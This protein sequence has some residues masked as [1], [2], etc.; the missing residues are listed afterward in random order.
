MIGHITRATRHLLFWSLISTAFLLS[1]ARIF[2]AGLDEY[3]LELEDKIRQAI[4]VPFKIGHLEAGLRGFNPEIILRDIRIEAEDPQNKPDLQLREIRLGL[5]FWH[6]LLSWDL[7]SASRVTLVGANVHLTRKEDGSLAIKG[8]HASDEQ[9]LWL[10]RGKQYEILDSQITWQDLK[11][12]GQKVHL[13]RFDVVLKN[14]FSDRS[15]EIHL[16]SSLPKQYGDSFRISA[17]VKGDIF[18]ADDI[19]GQLYIEGTDLQA[20]TLIT[21][22]LPLGLDLRSGAGDIKVWSAWKHSRPYQIDGYIQAQ[23]IDI[24]KNQGKPIHMDTFQASFAWSEDDGRWRLAGYD[25][26][27][28]TQRQRWPDGAFY[29]QQDTE[30]NLSALI[31]QLDLPAAMLLAPLIVPTGHDHA[32][33]LKLNPTG[34]LRDVSLFVSHDLQSYAVSGRFDDLGTDHYAAIPKLRHLSGQ[35]SV[36]DQYGQV[37]FDSHDVAADVDGLFRNTVSIKLLQGT[38][39]WWQDAE[40][41]QVYS[42]NLAMDSLDFQTLSSL[43]L[44]IPKTSASPVLDMR[45]HFGGFEDISQ[46]KK[47][48]PAKLMDEDAVAWLDDAFIKGRIRQGEMCIQGALDQFPFVT[49]QGRF[50]TVFTIENGE[51][52]FNEDWP[53][54]H[55]LYA[56]VQFLGEDLQVAISEGRSEKV[57]IDQAVVTIPALADSEHVYVW[58]KVR[59]QIMDG[60]AFL[61]QSPLRPQIEPV[62]KVLDGDGETQIDLD[63]KIP[64]AETDPVKVKVDAELKGAQLTLKPI[65]LKV[66]GIKGILNFTEDRIAS[67]PLEARTLGYPIQGRLSSDEQATYLGI[68]GSTSFERLKKQ[69]TFLPNDVASGS[70]SYQARLALPYAAEQPGQ[71]NITTDL[72]G[73]AIKAENGLAKTSD[74]EMPLRLNFQLD[75]GNL[76]PLQLHYGK[77]LQAELLIDKKRESLFSGHLVLG[78]G[79]ASRYGKEGLKIDIRQA[80]F[81]LSQA[82]SSFGNPEQSRFPQIREIAIDTPQLIWQG[83]SLGAFTGR[84]Q[85]QD[86]AW[87]GEL[88]SAMAKGAFHIPN[89]LGGNNRILL[90]MDYLNLSELSNFHLD[91]AENAVTELPLIDI[92]SRQLLWRTVDLGEL[93]LQTERLG[94]GIHFKKIQLHNGSSKIDVTADWLKLDSGTATQVKG[95]LDMENFGKFLS[96]LGYTDDI[97]ETSANISFKG[98]WH[99]GPHQFA[100]DRLNGFLQLDLKDGRISSIEPGF[101]RLLGL[102][103]M[104]QWVKRLSLDFS[105]VYRQGLAFDEI[106]GR[107]KIKNGLAFTDDLTIDAVAATFT[108]AGFTNL[109]DKTIDQRV[110]VVPKSSDALPIAGTIVDG[111]ASIITQVVTDDYKEG[112]FFGSKYKLSGNWGN[113]E[114]TPLHDEDG[115]LNKTWRGLTDFGWLDSITE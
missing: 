45:T 91:A 2:L 35:L 99:G 9:P 61:Q 25:V 50:E 39:H 40:A 14:H 88:N 78:Q 19:E 18:K 51:V 104:E 15:H 44:L 110:A 65:N 42:H 13:D 109:V 86:Q 37:I 59:A 21:G 112:Y 96:R 52:Q 11:R 27:I 95:S 75:A 55:D 76:L 79:Q 58:G 29:L 17:L 71:L 84:L 5:D 80:T 26:N 83:Q 4:D 108:I 82:L 85:H 41:W 62:A 101:G 32:E 48:L 92:N 93:R 70:F 33:W 3:Q 81:D 64:Y 16:V 74:E 69:F 77:Q 28:F 22:D 113:V 107:F 102:I 7:M 100:M 68:N 43:N 105:D 87:Q 24:S 94:N 31:R 46:V 30:G 49:G 90:D 89:Q 63:L 114:V 56:D 60:L 6:L 47:Y 111:I 66:D 72:K 8:L 38:L 115:L 67:G 12:H 34:R 73:V 106:K 97:K 57:D 103:A 53:Q 10:L 54:L 20:A 98:G 1:A 36:T 23:Q